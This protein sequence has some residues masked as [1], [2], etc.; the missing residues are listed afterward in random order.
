MPGRTREGRAGTAS[1][2]SGSGAA[3]PCF[4]WNNGG[5]TWNTGGV[6]R[7]TVVTEGPVGRSGSRVG[8]LP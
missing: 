7:D 1:A 5:F 6:T 8:V 2:S 3:L 4:T